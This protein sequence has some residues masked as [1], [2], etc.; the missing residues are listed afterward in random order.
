MSAKAILNDLIGHGVQLQ[1]EGGNLVV[2][3]PPGVLT[4]E[5]CQAL[6]AHKAE[7][8]EVLKAG[9]SPVMAAVKQA[10][11][12]ICDAQEFYAF[13]SPEDIEDIEAGRIT[14]Q[15]LRS[16][17]QMR[18]DRLERETRVQRTTPWAKAPRAQERQPNPELRRK[19]LQQLADNPGDRGVWYSGRGHMP[20]R[21]QNV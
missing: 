10:C 16:F 4:P 12:G 19:V 20:V 8:L 21:W 1:A 9:P 15:E 14:I 18:R 2:D 6:R 11:E 3:A 7:L 13:L 5:V 17:A